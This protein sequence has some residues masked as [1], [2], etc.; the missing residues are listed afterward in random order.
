MSTSSGLRSEMLLNILQ[1][2]GRHRIIPPNMPIVMR[3][4]NRELRASNSSKKS[5]ERAC[6]RAESEKEL[7]KRK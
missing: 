1:C 5:E 2:T 7:E 3:L 4:R 6:N